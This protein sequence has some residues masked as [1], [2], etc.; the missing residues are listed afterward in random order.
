MKFTRAALPSFQVVFSLYKNCP[1][2]C[3]PCPPTQH[4]PLRQCL[5]LNSILF[6]IITVKLCSLLI[7]STHPS[8]SHI[9][10]WESASGVQKMIQFWHQWPQ[11]TV[12]LPVSLN[13]WCWSEFWLQITFKREDEMLWSRLLRSPVFSYIKPS[14]CWFPHSPNISALTQVSGLWG[15]LFP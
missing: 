12:F 5:W 8:V 15:S 11:A 1:Y 4:C 9:R 3:C 2:C 14:S 6:S 10:S 13:V 7:P